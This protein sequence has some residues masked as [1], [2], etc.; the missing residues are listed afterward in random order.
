MYC[1]NNLA[2]GVSRCA[3]EELWAEL[4]LL[5]AE[6]T[7]AEMWR[8]FW[9]GASGIREYIRSLEQ[10]DLAGG[11]PSSATIVNQLISLRGV[12]GLCY[13]ALWENQGTDYTAA[14]SVCVCGGG[15]PHEDISVIWF[16]SI[17]VSERH[18]CSFVRLFKWAIIDWTWAPSSVMHNIN[19]VSIKMGK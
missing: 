16:L 6:E 5:S 7:Y 17:C 15:I 8:T 11:Q 4:L 14:A 13:N 18:H 3:L 19:S 10:S 9:G 12:L 1:L 2:N